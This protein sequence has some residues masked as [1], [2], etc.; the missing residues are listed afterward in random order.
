MLDAWWSVR[1]AFSG[2][3][4]TPQSWGSSAIFRLRDFRDHLEGGKV[5]E[6]G[7]KGQVPGHFYQ[8]NNSQHLS[9]D[10]FNPWKIL[11]KNSLPV[12]V[13]QEEVKKSMI[14]VWSLSRKTAAVRISDVLILVCP[15]LALFSW[16]PF[17][18]YL[19]VSAR[20]QRN[21]ILEITLVSTRMNR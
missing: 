13:E 8:I 20:S 11:L 3:R 5:S 19:L 18:I 16:S 15:A 4:L 14:L 6:S 21:S 10:F 1:F 7:L 2:A 17:W 9:K 12:K